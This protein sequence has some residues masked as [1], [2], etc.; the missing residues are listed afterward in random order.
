ME[1]IAECESDYIRLA[2][3][4]GATP[5]AARAEWDELVAL[6]EEDGNGD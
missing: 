5:E 2:V 1:L 4:L 6:K 3:E